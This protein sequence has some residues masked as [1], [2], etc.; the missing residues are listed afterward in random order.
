MIHVLTIVMIIT[1]FYA[2]SNIHVSRVKEH[3]YKAV[4]VPT[5]VCGSECWIL[6]EQLDG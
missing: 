1:L 3:F 4:A 6:M 5:E 2:I